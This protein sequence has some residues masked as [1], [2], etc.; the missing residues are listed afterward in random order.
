MAEDKPE[1]VGIAG[2]PKIWAVAVQLVG[3]FG[4]AVFLVLYYVLV[5]QPAEA[6]RYDKLATA[7]NDLLAVVRADQTLLSRPQVE[8]LEELFVQ[9]AAPAVAKVLMDA[10]AAGRG[11]ANLAREIENEMMLRVDLFKGLTREDGG[12]VASQLQNK[13]LNQELPQRLAELASG[14][15]RE[16]PA[17]EV[18]LQT[19]NFVRS[20]IH[21]AARAK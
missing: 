5:L 20:A 4:L 11:E 19:T 1:P 10:R 16:M 14:E 15:W 13:I 6:E 21:A 7:V 17:G 2:L 9:A 8:A 12:V 18:T 3:T